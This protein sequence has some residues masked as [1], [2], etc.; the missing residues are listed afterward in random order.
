M[1]AEDKA[2]AVIAELKKDSGNFAELAKAKCQRRLRCQRR[3]SG[4]VLAEHDGAAVRAGGR[5]AGEGQVQRRAGADSS[6]A[7]M[8][9]CWR[10]LRDATPPSLDEL[11]PQI[12]QMLQ[13]KMLNDYLEKL[14][15]G[16][17]IEVTEIKVSEAKPAAV[18]KEAVKE[19]KK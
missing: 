9:S 16:A 13:S 11:K 15:S 4:L 8:S 10:I 12:Q 1:D 6:S 2:K 17:K 3:R 5:Q 14:K 18:A 7:G 19:E